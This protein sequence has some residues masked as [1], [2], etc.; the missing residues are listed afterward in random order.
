MN[1]QANVIARTIHV[2]IGSGATGGSGGGGSV[3]ATQEANLRELLG[4]SVP[5]QVAGGGGGGGGQLQRQEP[6]ISDLMDIMKSMQVQI[7]ALAA[8]NIR[9]E[10]QVTDVGTE[11]VA[12]RED[13]VDV[14][15]QVLGAVHY[16]GV[17]TRNKIRDLSEQINQLGRRLGNCEFTSVQGIINCLIQLWTLLCVIGTYMKTWVVYIHQL[18]YESVVKVTGTG[19]PFILLIASGITLLI[20]YIL[21]AIFATFI[22]VLIGRPELGIELTIYVV[23]LAQAIF[24]AICNTLQYLATM[25]GESFIAPFFTMVSKYLKIPGLMATVTAWY[26]TLQT[27][28]IM[29]I[30]TDAFS[31][32]WTWFTAALSGKIENTIQKFIPKMPKFWG[33]GRKS[34]KH[35]KKWTKRLSKKSKKSKKSKGKYRI[36]TKRLKKW[37]Y[38]KNKVGGFDGDINSLTVKEYETSSQH[39]FE[40]FTNFMKQYN[41]PEIVSGITISSDNM[42]LII[43]TFGMMKFLPDIIDILTEDTMMEI[44]KF[45]ETPPDLSIEVLVEVTDLFKNLYPVLCILV[46]DNLPEPMRLFPLIL[47]S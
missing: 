5:P 9:L 34:K 7:A 29:P 38:N 20:D 44:D 41:T 39:E 18:V 21:I 6:N 19:L 25:M 22:G 23:A 17:L 1:P 33:G 36:K 24:I 11:V 46:N 31:N 3:V 47:D 14:G 43:T 35:Y 4:P 2:A 32:A 40:K 15:D 12:V 10:Q 45:I 16:E 28:G 30:I 27:R 42:N 26:T 37:K 8:Q 13:V